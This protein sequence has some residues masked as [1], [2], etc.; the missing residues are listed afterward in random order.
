M[1]YLYSDL[2]TDVRSTA[3]LPSS[4]P[5]GSAD[6]DI[7]AHADKMM[8][9]RLVPA[10][11]QAREEWFVRTQ[12]YALTAGLA[13]YRL[14]SRAIAGRLRSVQLVISG[15][16]INLARIEPSRIAEFGLV[17]TQTQGTPW[18]YYLRG[19]NIVLC[20]PPA[21]ASNTLRIQYLQRPGRLSSTSQ[22]VAT[23]NTT[24]GV[25]T[26]TGAHG[27]ANGSDVDFIA[28]SSPFETKA[29]GTL[30][31][32]SGTGFTTSVT[33]FGA[34]P[35]AVGDYFVA[36]G[37]TP[38][39]QLPPEFYYVLVARTAAAL[40]LSLGFREEAAQ[41]EQHAD[42]L[43]GDALAMSKVRTEGEPRKVVGGLFWRNRRGYLGWGY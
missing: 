14:P 21:S 10:L 15:A 13:E 37:T 12:D 31:A 16:T 23:L 7:L 25:G 4:S 41:Q 17:A 3:M 18:A 20:P 11:V 27:I 1:A 28:S 5:S 19:A 26:T 2:L 38:V 39:V 29:T 42:T 8:A 6:A 32:A 30:S 33:D 40:M 36:A 43:M 24:T 34:V 9:T 35:P 22:T